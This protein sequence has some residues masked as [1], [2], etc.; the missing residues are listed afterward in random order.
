MIR[1]IFTCVFLILFLVLTLPV[2]LVLWLIGKKWPAAK[3]KASF[4]IV[5]WGFS[6]LVFISGVKLTVIGE[7]NIPKDRSVLYIGNHRSYFDIII[8]YTLLPSLTGYM[9]KKEMDRYP[10]LNIWMRNIHCLF[11]DRTDIRQGMETIKAAIELVK[12]G[13][14]VFI[15]PEGTRN[16]ADS[17]LDLMEFHEGSFRVATR[18]GCPIVPV[19]MHNTREVLEAHM[20]RIRR[21]PVTVEFLP[22]I[23]PGSL[24][25]DEQKHLGVTIRELMQETLKKYSS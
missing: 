4:R 2:L 16:K 7:E 15:Y 20:P 6:V 24:S 19:V 5:K 17:E 14:S 23:D 21:V 10:V 18:S 25:R 3:D 12:N 11:L 1:L 13:I 8:G 22:P 9:A